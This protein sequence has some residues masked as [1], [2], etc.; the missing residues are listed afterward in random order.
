M[1]I[2]VFSKMGTGFPSDFEVVERKGRGHPDTLADRLAERLSVAYSKFTKDKFGTILR[3]QF[4]KLSLMGG[5]TDVNFNY[6]KIVSPVRLLLNGRVT[7]EIGNEKI[8]FRD[9]LFDECETFLNAELK[10]F[11]FNSNCRVV[12][13]TSFNSTRGLVDNQGKNAINYRFKPR[14]ISDLPESHMPL[15]NDTAVG[16]AFAPLSSVEKFVIEIEKHLSGSTIKEKYP[17]L[18]SD[19][20][21]MAYRIRNDVKLTLAIPQI[22][23]LVT[24]ATE[25]VNNS[26]TVYELIYHIAEK[27]KPLNISISINPSDDMSKEIL[28][29]RHTGSSIESGDEGVVGRGNRIDGIISSCRPYSIEGLNGKNPAYHAGK[30]YSAAAWDIAN[31]IWEKLG[32]ASEVFIIS[33]IDRPLI[34]PWK[35]IIN[36][37]ANEI[38]NKKIKE[39]TLGIIS[40]TN[41]ITSNILEGKYPFC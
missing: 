14:N 39:I 13:E 15:A 10:N 4:D 27:Y 26:K 31:S 19:I 36:C 7:R 9:L 2:E 21:V 18:G 28:Y 35:I 41:N 16:C 17:W 6:G 40:D 24:S 1:D 5:R 3:H 29:L 20:K 12:F 11:D 37:T 32:I 8:N 30:I 34:D 22:S 38:S 33:Q 25:Y 23:T